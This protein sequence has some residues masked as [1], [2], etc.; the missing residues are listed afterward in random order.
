MHTHGI[1]VEHEEDDV[2]FG[3]KKK[4]KQQINVTGLINFNFESGGTSNNRDKF[5]KRDQD[6]IIKDKEGYDMHMQFLSQ[7]RI[8]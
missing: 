1:N 4:K 7:R 5:K 2:N 3:G 6:D 8:K